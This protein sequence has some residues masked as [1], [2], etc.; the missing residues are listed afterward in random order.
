VLSRCQ[1][2]LPL[3]VMARGLEYT[4]PSQVFPGCIAYR[5]IGA[6][7]CTSG[8]VPLCGHTVAGGCKRHRSAEKVAL[9]DFRPQRGQNGHLVSVS[10]PSRTHLRPRLRQRVMTPATISLEVGPRSRKCNTPF[11]GGG[12]LSQLVCRHLPCPAGARRSSTG[13]DGAIWLESS[14]YAP[15]GDEVVLSSRVTTNAGWSII[16]PGASAQNRHREEKFKEYRALASP[17]HLAVKGGLR[18]VMS[19]LLPLRSRDCSL[20]TKGIREFGRHL[21]SGRGHR[22]ACGVSR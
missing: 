19:E 15:I 3:E 8:N 21:S 17:D 16:G 14:S 2:A 11:L 7:A 20:S 18:V 22:M 1:S 5:V 10:T 12:P 4:R 6:L 9:Y 13:G